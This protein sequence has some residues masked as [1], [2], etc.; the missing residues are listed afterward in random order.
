METKKKSKSGQKCRICLMR[1]DI[2]DIIDDLEEM[3][4]QGYKKR[5][6]LAKYP[7]FVGFYH[8]LD[9][10]LRNHVDRKVVEARIRGYEVDDAGDGER[11]KK[12]V[13]PLKTAEQIRQD[14]YYESIRYQEIE[15]PSTHTDSR[16]ERSRRQLAHILPKLVEEQNKPPRSSND[17]LPSIPIPEDTQKETFQPRRIEDLD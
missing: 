17:H 14:K 4:V 15:Q 5:H 8:N 1:K 13:L 9:R 10:H 16:A 3:H 6:I 12:I 11:V 2:P 7:V